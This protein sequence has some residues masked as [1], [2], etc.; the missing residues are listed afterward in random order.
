MTG[1][2]FKIMI[3]DDERLNINVLNHILKEEYQIRVAVNGEQALNRA[4]S[5]PQPDLILLDIQMPGMDG[6]E[7]CQ[8]LKANEATQHIP[9]IFITAMGK[10]AD[11]T[12]GLALGAVDYITKPISPAIVLARVKTQLT[13][14]KT[15]EIQKQQNHVLYELNQTKNRFLGMVAHDLRSPLAAIQSISQILQNV[16]LSREKQAFFLDRIHQNSKQMFTLMNDLLD[17]SVIESGK[18]DLQLSQCDLVEVIKNQVEMVSWT[19]LQKQIHIETSYGTCAPFTLDGN[20][21]GQV[22]DNLLTNAIKFSPTNTTVQV[23]CYCVD[24]QAT[25]TIQDQGTGI[26][27]EEQNMLFG[28]FQTLSS[29]PTGNEKSSGLGLAIVKKIVDAHHGTISL[30]SEPGN[31]CTFQVTL[32]VP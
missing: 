20:R 5:V 15:L 27:K 12:K 9:I 16:D 6:Y 7:I 3:V 21:I 1:Q 23:S 13:L 11:E 30:Q 14:K 29:Q 28:P 18:F 10:T 4:L 25:I 32:P 2:K 17:I 22:I 26:R 31:G 24:G 19:A 8:Q